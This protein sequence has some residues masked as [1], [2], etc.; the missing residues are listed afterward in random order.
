M[1]HGTSLSSSSGSEIAS[2]NYVARNLGVTKGM[3]IGTARG[4]CPDLRVVPYDFVVGELSFQIFI[5]IIL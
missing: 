3:W 5:L 1:S 2:C 4:L